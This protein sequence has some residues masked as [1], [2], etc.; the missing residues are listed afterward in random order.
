MQHHAKALQTAWESEDF[1]STY[2][3]TYVK[4]EKRELVEALGFD[5][6]AIT[7]QQIDEA[8]A[9]TSLVM[10]D[11]TISGMLYQFTKDYAEAQYAIEITSVAGSAAVVS[12]AH[13]IRKFQKVGDLLQDFSKAMGAGF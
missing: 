7:E 13:L 11:P 3:K 6:T 8:M 2:A 9:M 1:S 5:P 10:D 4:G 12:K